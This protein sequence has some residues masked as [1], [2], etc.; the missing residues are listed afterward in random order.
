M[1]RRITERVAYCENLKSEIPRSLIVCML[2]M[3]RISRAVCEKE[4]PSGVLFSCR[5]LVQYEHVGF[6]F[7][8]QVLASIY[9]ST[10]GVLSSIHE[11]R[12]VS[13]QPTVTVEARIGSHS[14]DCGAISYLI[15]LQKVFL[16]VAR[17]RIPRRTYLRG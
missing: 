12:H 4:E 8:C 13:R 9:R 7:G 17:I 1:F 16:T 15:I 3:L 11:W 2:R 14:A 10:P 5:R 6:G